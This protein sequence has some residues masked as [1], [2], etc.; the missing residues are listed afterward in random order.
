MSY[1]I[2]EK[3]K[4]EIANYKDD[5]KFEHVGL[6]TEVGDGIAKISGLSRA[7]SQELLNI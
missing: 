5:T 1:E 3:L 2:I 6:V 7:L 4:R